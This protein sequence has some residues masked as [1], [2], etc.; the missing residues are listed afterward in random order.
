MPE[1]LIA[2]HRLS[3]PRGAAGVDIVITRQLRTIINDNEVMML[4]IIHW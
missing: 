2:V 3:C 1:M 4:I